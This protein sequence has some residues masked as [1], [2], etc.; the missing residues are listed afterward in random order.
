MYAIFVDVEAFEVQYGFSKVK[1]REFK[2]EIFNLG[3][4]IPHRQ[5]F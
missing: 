1:A 5:I 2:S 4:L 3:Q